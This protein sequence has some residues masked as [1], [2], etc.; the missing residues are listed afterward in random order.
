MPERVNH[1][2]QQSLAA[3]GRI[4]RITTDRHESEATPLYRAVFCKVEDVRFE[5]QSFRSA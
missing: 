1:F 2:P 3:V 5:E 4:S